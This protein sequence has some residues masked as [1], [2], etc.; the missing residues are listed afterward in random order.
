MSNY[1]MNI[2]N[3]YVYTTIDFS[4]TLWVGSSSLYIVNTTIGKCSICSK[5]IK[6]ND[7]HTSIVV[8]LQKELY[9][10]EKCTDN[11]LST[12]IVANEL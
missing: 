4:G 3:G 2:N 11:K 1:N 12:I 9:L 10:C 8:S 5:E 6:Y 7:R